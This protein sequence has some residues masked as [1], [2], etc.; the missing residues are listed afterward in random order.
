MARA[1]MTPVS[2][3]VV[4][5][6]P[7]HRLLAA[8]ALREAGFEVT[9]ASS[10]EEALE[11]AAGTDLV[12]LDYRLP[13]MTGMEVLDRLRRLGGPAV[14]FVTGMGSEE[15]AVEAM[16][17]G[18][19]DYIVKNPGYLAALPKAVDRAWRHHDLSRRAAELERLVLLVN[20]ASAR[21]E[22]LPEIARGLRTLLRADACAVVVDGGT[23]PSVE[24]VDGNPTLGE[25]EIRRAVEASPGAAPGGDA[26]TDRLVVPLPGR[27]GGALGGI[28]VM[29]QAPRRHLPEE[30]RLAT[31]FASFAGLALANVTRLDLERRLATELQAMLDMRTRLVTSVSHELRTPLTAILGFAE[32]L[33]ARWDAIPDGHRREFVS[34][35]QRQASGLADLVDGLLDYAT[36]EAGR[37][38]AD[39]APFALSPCIDAALEDLAPLLMGR[40]VEVDAEAAVVLGD[41]V[42]LRRTLTNLL[43]NAVKYSDAG[44][45]ITIRY[46]PAGDR[47]RIEVVDRGPGLTRDEAAAAFEP[48]WRGSRGDWTVHGNG[49]GLSLVREYARLM[50][51]EAGVESEPGRGSVFYIT[52]PLAAGATNGAALHGS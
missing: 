30:V 35:I 3:L 12:L 52:L 23:G 5:D 42:L 10:G 29:M 17:A 13:R 25:E 14:I 6:D 47:C 36:M 39:I 15:I 19:V 31:T 45:A 34:I 26:A 9:V 51:G 22:V 21:S 24:A 49:I 27:D 33:D 7:D 40:P 32:T 16:R 50:K 2:V 41:P 38:R 28:V 1:D 18:A 11:L 46:H 8:R 43:S 48:F 4:E 37:V 20:S 44:S